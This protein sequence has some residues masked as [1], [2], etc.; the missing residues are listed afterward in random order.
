MAHAV[1][2]HF[3]EEMTDGTAECNFCH[4]NCGHDFIRCF[5]LKLTLADESAKIL[6][7]CSGHTATE[8]LQIS[9]DDFTA[10]PEVMYMIPYEAF[11]CFG[12]SKSDVK[13]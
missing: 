13:P 4:Q 8:L 3:V 10:L 5:H 6:A 11:F 2:G 12:I 7:W 9:P 1:C